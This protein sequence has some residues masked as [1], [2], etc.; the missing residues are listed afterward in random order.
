MDS[1]NLVHR[2]TE[3]LKSSPINNNA[4]NEQKSPKL[5]CNKWVKKVYLQPTKD[6]KSIDY[7][8]PSR[9]INAAYLQDSSLMSFCEPLSQDEKNIFRKS[10]VG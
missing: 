4:I 2:D 7:S 8:K 10:Q 5:R 3:I 1:K 6:E 9:N